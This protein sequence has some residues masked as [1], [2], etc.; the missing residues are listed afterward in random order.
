GLGGNFLV[1]R[2]VYALARSSGRLVSG[3][4]TARTGLPQGKDELGRLTLAF[5]LMA[6]ALEQRELERKG[7]SHKLQIL[8]HRLVEVQE[9]ERRQIARELHDEIG[10]SL[11][12]AEMNLQAALKTSGQAKMSHRL[13][14]SIQAVE[15]V[16]EQVHDLFL[17][18]RLYILDV[19]G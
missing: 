19:L 9:T 18:L 1:L 8:S 7:A 6:Q 10:Q 17:N 2:P 3:D 11:T 16:L 12:V 14:E 5:D 13:Q 4:L 15:R